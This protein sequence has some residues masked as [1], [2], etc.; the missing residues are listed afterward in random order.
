MHDIVHV[1]NQIQLAI[2]ATGTDRNFGGYAVITRGPRERIV[3][4]PFV[5]GCLHWL[6]VAENCPSSITIVL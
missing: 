4:P 1:A 6:I 5:F 3:P 2:V